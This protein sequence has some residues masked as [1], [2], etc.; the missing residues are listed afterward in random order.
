MTA[1][2]GGT[3][4]VTLADGRVLAVGGGVGI[5]PAAAT[6][7]FDPARTIW[8]RT[9]DLRHARRGNSSVALADGRV[10]TAGGVDGSSALASA[11][12]YDPARGE[13]MGVAP[14]HE[15]RF[16]FTMTALAD[17]RVLVAGGASLDDGAVAPRAL[18]SAEVY[19][20]AA[21]RWTEVGG[22]KAARYG[23]AAVA[24]AD[25][26]ILVVGGTAPATAD[27]ASASP[28]LA[29]AEQFDPGTAAFA[30]VATMGSP[31]AE[32]T[33]TALAN[34]QVLVAGG[35]SGSATLASSELYDPVHNRWAPTGALGQGRQAHAAS[36]LA[37]GWVLVTGG[38]TVDL[39][40]RRSL[41]TAEV[42]DPALGRWKPAAAMRCARS[43]QAQVTLASGRVLVAGGDSLLPAQP[44][45]PQSCSEV[46]DPA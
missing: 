5:R 30:P 39:G 13:W 15:G 34:G 3:T 2:R 44:V 42:Y 4:A 31:R 14:M 43:A 45:Q 21:D 24:L 11:E 9:G 20:S 40:A 1:L 16:G 10:L 6:E 25:G 18:S 36:R 26:R 7:V 28:S 8:T 27:D 33:A 32:P 12:V 46:F 29:T 38:D 19:D 23:A 35:S 41:R 17:G 37:S 22:L